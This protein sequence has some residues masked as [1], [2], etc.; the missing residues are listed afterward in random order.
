MPAVAR[1]QLAKA[2]LLMELDKIR[3]CLGTPSKCAVALVLVLAGPGEMS[4]YGS[5]IV[6]PASWFGQ[7]DRIGAGQNQNRFPEK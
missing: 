7:A 4:N 3:Y 6:S 1:C 2:M 5:E